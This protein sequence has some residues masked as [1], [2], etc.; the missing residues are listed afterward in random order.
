MDSILT[1]IK[2]MLGYSAEDTGYDEEIMM[3]INAV[4]MDLTQMGV[5]PEEGFEIDDAADQW[6]DFVSDVKK[7]A[8]IKTYVYMKMKLIFDDATMSSALIDSYNRRIAELE[9]RLTHAA[10]F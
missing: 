8:G 1:S 6:D 4:L 2:T 9:W 10:E 7:F 5:G 3:H